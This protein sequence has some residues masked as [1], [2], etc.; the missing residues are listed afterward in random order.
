MLTAAEH[1]MQATACSLL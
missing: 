1:V